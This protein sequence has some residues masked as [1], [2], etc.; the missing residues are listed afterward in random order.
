[1]RLE[2]DQA[3]V[4]GDSIARIKP[5]SRYYYPPIRGGLPQPRQSRTP[6]RQGGN[7]GQPS[8]RRMDKNLPL[9]IQASALRMAIYRRL[10]LATQRAAGFLR[11]SPNVVSKIHVFAVEQS[12]QS[13]AEILAATPLSHE[14]VP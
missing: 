5:L 13:S 4:E 8:A 9:R 7:I 2:L 6:F 12:G 11:N 10:F 3:L 14:I 1:M